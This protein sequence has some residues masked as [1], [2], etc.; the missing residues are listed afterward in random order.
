MSPIYMYTG[1]EVVLLVGHRTCDSQVVVSRPGWAP[2]FSGL[3]HGH[4]SYTCVPLSVTKQY[5]LVPAKG[6]CC[7]AE[8]V[9]VGLVDNNGSLPPGL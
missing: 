1:D 3:G 6:H 9:T 7:L 5:N 4:A 8:N 2:P